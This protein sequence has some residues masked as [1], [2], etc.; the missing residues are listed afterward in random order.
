[1]T[2][3][4]REDECARA[5]E[6]RS[7][8]L[9][10]RGLIAGAAALVVGL[11]AAR[12][13]ET[14]DAAQLV[15]TNGYSGSLDANADGVQGYASGANNAGLFGRNNSANGLGV[16]G[17]GGNGIGVFGQSNSGPGLSGH[18]AASIGTYG[19]SETGIGVVGLAKAT[20]PDANKTTVGVQGK[21]LT[22]AGTFG[23][24]T[25][26]AA[27][28]PP[29]AVGV[30][31][32]GNA[33]AGVSGKSP[34]SSGVAGVTAS[35][36]AAA[37]TGV[38]YA[39]ASYTTYGNAP[40]MYG[41]SGGGIGVQG[42]SDSGY[43][44]FGFST[45]G[46]G[47]QGTSTNTYGVVGSSTNSHGIVGASGPAGTAGILGYTTVNGALAGLF[48]GPVSVSANTP[49]THAVVATNNV[50][51]YG[52]V[53]GQT[54][55]AG[56]VGIYGYVNPS[57]GGANAS[58]GYFVGKVTVVG[59]FAVT[60]VKA[61]LVAHPD[62]TH[63][64][65]HCVEAPEAWFEDFGRAR[66]TAGTATV[67]LDPDFAALVQL[68]DYFVYLTAEGETKG[69]AVTA[70]TP[71]GFTVKEQQGGTSGTEFAYR[72]V[73]RR[74]DVPA[75]RLAKVALAKVE[76][77]PAPP[78]AI[79][80]PAVLAAPPTPTI[81]PVPKHAAEDAAATTTGAL[82]DGATQAVAAKERG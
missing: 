49:S 11:A 62:G 10:R 2:E 25:W 76:A 33:G 5:S 48:Q 39:N 17:I 42:A 24:N 26:T 20:T 71:T 36:S 29:N 27:S 22:D 68:A 41:R 8:A 69:L 53:F 82:P 59:D 47:V 81:P 15:G 56:G 73:A 7:G 50:A 61:A 77:P 79:T 58:A 55:A 16:F 60:G 46:Y 23:W 34:G 37:V 65:L 44:V 6:T 72:V 51:G 45:S 19:E 74:K 32:L 12:S 70:R 67:T 30:Y 38:A 75:G 14:V 64:L 21:S 3:Q 35:G 31:G 40:G 57:V 80:L 78:K 13:T 4:R 52:A 1:M 66:L 63:R 43:G 9:K 28:P 18:S 54:N